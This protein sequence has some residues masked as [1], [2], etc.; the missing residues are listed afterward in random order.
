MVK[1]RVRVVTTDYWRPGTDY[2]QKILGYVKEKVSDGDFVVVSEK[3]ISTALGNVVDESRIKPKITARMIAAGWMP[4][5]WGRILGN[6]CHFHKGLIEKLRRYPPAEG[7][8]HKQVALQ[9]AGFLHALMFGSEGGI[10]GA[11]LPYSYVSLPLK[12]AH[13]TA[14]SIRKHLKSDFSKIVSVM[15]VDT[16]KTYSLRSLHFTPRST[17]VAGI[18]S[19]GGVLTYLAGRIFMLKKRATPVAFCGENVTTEEM[20]QIADLANRSRG[21][22]SG[23]TV[24]D[25]AARFH[26]ELTKVTWEMLDTVKHKPIVILKRAE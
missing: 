15:I 4:V 24:W 10:D 18:H 11:N 9:Q 2:L 23:R 5:V 13:T 16:D 12:D 14:K 19:F 1:Y 21:Y 20:L 3:S 8:R 6:L 22:G 25:M 17:S 7:S 26:V